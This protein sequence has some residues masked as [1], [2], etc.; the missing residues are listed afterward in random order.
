MLVSDESGALSLQ[1]FPLWLV[2]VFEHH[3]FYCFSGNLAICGIPP[4]WSALIIAHLQR[5]SSIVS[6]FCFF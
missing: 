1:A 4:E 5:E 2:A 6:V 3:G